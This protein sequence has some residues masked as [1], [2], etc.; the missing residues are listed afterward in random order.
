MRN[1]AIYTQLNL[2]VGE[3][4]MIPAVRY[5]NNSQRGNVFIPSASVVFN[6]YR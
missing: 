4:I 6:K 5:D 2:S 3:I 1:H